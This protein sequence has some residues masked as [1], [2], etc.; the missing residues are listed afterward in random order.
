MT[1]VALLLAVAL[2]SRTKPAAL[3]AS[4]AEWED[5]CRDAGGWEYIDAEARTGARNEFG[6]EVSGVADWIR[7]QSTPSNH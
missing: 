4:G 2:P 6:G 5:L 1:L 7:S 3:E